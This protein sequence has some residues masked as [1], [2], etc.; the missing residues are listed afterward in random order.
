MGSY[1]GDV[2]ELILLCC[3]P[4]FLFGLVVFGGYRLYCMLVGEDEAGRPWLMA[5]AALSTPLREVGHVIACMLCWHRI[6][7]MRLLDLRSPDGEWGYVEHS[8]NPRNPVA[9][10]GNFLYAL[11]PV[12]VGL[13]AVLLIFATCFY[14]VLPS[15]FNEISALNAAAAGIGDYARAA[16]S[17]IPT[18]FT[19]DGAPM[20]LRVFGCVLLL[21]VCVGIHVSVA[22]MMDALGGFLIFSGFSAVAA[23]ALLLFDDRVRRIFFGG[24]RAYAAGVTALF[25]VV[26]LCLAA[27]LAVALI[28]RV[29]RTLFSRGDAGGAV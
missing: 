28:F 27:L 3:A 18:M 9:I 1:L 12:A 15:F 6:E 26:M 21:A 11:G 14:G 16:F 22:E 10:F 8:Y 19:A 25:A 7:D 4:P 20:L 29:M 5:V 2:L 24:L 17:L 13:C 23:G